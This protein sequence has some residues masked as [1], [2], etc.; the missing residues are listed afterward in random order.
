MK[1]ILFNPFEKY[2]DRGLMIAGIVFTLL[3]SLLGYWCRARFDGILDLH[4]V[5]S[6]FLYEPFIDNFVNILSLSFILFLLGKYLNT[7]TRFI[8]L[9][10]TTMIARTPI[11]LLS[12]M[13]IGGNMSKMSEQFFSIM[14]PENAIPTAE[15]DTLMAI[16]TEHAFLLTITSI[17]TILGLIWYI[18]LL[19]NG[20]KIASHAKGTKSVV[21]FI[22]AILVAELLS[23]II[24]YKMY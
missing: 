1:T 7:K 20:F 24:I 23:K 14:N 16:L 13:N 15:I 18:A 17:A 3:G 22:A 2:A 8:D 21:L 19:L 12:L 5:L 10:I 11:Y 6:G 9:L 4:F